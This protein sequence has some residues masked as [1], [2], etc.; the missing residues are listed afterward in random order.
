MSVNTIPLNMMQEFI[1]LNQKT[2]AGMTAFSKLREEDIAVGTAPKEEI[3]R[4]N[5]MV[6]YHITPVVEK[7]FEIPV[8][9]SYALV[10]RP[11]VADLQADRS[12]IRNL[13]K[14]GL[15]VYLIDWGYPTRADRWLTL[16]DYIND[17]IDTCVDIIRERHGLDKINILG[18]CQGGT[19]SLC[20][21]SLHQEKVKN[22]VLT[23]TPVDFSVGDSLINQWGHVVGE[24]KMD[25]DQMV[26]A[27]GNIPG[28]FMN[29]G[30]VYLRPFELNLRKYFNMADLF[31]SQDKLANFLRMENWI[32]DSPDLAG[33]AY[34]QFMKDFY[35][36]NKLVKG[37][38]ELGGQ[39]VDLSSI[40]IPVLNIYAA[41]DTIVPPASTTALEKYIGSDDYSTQSYPVG[42]IGMY[43]SGKVQQTMPVAVADWYKARA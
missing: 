37:E 3:Y 13:V 38:V 12:L 42:H 20:Y 16:D 8:L 35:L 7:P 14:L 1:E 2:L 11:A 23:V 19:F 41:Q 40:K 25:V 33:E 24:A 27:F 21:T 26:D 32:F 30:F 22:L 18:I 10:N 6:L 36:G 31:D 39:R 17:Y 4:E 15:D 9:I 5:K 29:L 34:R 28:D 43:V